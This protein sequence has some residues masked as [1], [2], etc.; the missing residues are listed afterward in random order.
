MIKNLSIIILKQPQVADFAKARNQLMSQAKT[1]W[2][3][4]VDTDESL[5]PALKKEIKLAIQN[6]SYNYQLKR[7]DWFLG[8]KLNFGETSAVRL[9]R[10]IQKGTGQW[11]GRI[12]EVFK[13]NLPTKTLKQPLIH[14]RHLTLNQFIDRLNHYSS[15]RASELTK[16]S[17]FQLLFYPPAKF[18]HNYFFRLGFL[19]GLPGLAMAFMMSLHSLMVR[20]K[21]YELQKT[22]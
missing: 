21:L 19:D 18:V 17:L 15:I 10:L 5:T 11:Q 12:H 2:I 9:T 6:Q 13:S 1:D 3:L 20:L 7:Q 14:Q 8:K 16:F 4:F 22:S